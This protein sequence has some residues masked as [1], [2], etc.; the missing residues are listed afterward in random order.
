MA[1]WKPPS[2]P[3]CLVLQRE[4]VVKQLAFIEKNSMC[5]IICPLI[6]LCSSKAW[7][8][9]FAFFPMA[10]DDDDGEQWLQELLEYNRKAWDQEIKCT[11]S[12][13]Y[14]MPSNRSKWII[15]KSNLVKLHW[16]CGQASPVSPPK[17]VGNVAGSAPWQS[18]IVFCICPIQPHTCWQKR[19]R[20]HHWPGTR[21]GPLPW[22]LQH[23]SF[24]GPGNVSSLLMLSLA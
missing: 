8:W 11:C 24:L 13:F 4:V 16:C 23:Y 15:Y 3:S 10:G 12:T 14:W 6:D 1:N 17:L 20:K 19:P 22:T 9:C 7:C 2:W 5:M 18:D 21:S